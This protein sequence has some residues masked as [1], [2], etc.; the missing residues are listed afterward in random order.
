METQSMRLSKAEA[1]A[2]ADF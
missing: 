2:E 1:Q